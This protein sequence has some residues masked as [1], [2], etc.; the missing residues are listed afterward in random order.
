MKEKI[1]CLKTHMKDRKTNVHYIEFKV[2]K[3]ITYPKDWF[4]DID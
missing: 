3:H 4:G 1:A 2:T